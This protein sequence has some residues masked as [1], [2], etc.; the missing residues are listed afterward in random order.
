[1]QSPASTVD[2]DHAQGKA[3]AAVPACPGLQTAAAVTFMKRHLFA[4]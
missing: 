2:P 1:M 3:A 4:G